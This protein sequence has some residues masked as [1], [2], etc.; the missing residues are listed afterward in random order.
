M[1]AFLTTV[2]FFISLGAFCQLA[3]VLLNDTSIT[4][5]LRD[6][7]VLELP[8]NSFLEAREGKGDVKYKM[9]A[10]DFK[11]ETV[12][13]CN[14]I[15]VGS[16]QE[17]D[18]GFT[19]L[20]KL[21]GDNCNCGFELFISV[22][23]ETQAY[24]SAKV[25]DPK[26]NRLTFKFK[27][28]DKEDFLGFGEQPSHYNLTGHKFPVF[29]E[30]QGLGRGD[31]HISGL[32]KLAGAAG[33]EYTSYAPIPFFLTDN[34]R[35]MLIDNTEYLEYDLTASETAKIT[36]WS[37][38]ISGWVWQ[39]EP[40]EILE[41]YT[42][43]SGRMPEL[44]DWAY[45]TWLGL[46]GGAEKVKTIVQGAMDAG[47]PVSAVWIQDWV[48]KRKT[49]IGSRLW[50]RWTPDEA[51]YPN[52]KQFNADM[53]E[54]GVKVLGYINS[55]L[56]D[57]GPMFEEAKSKGYLVKNQA[58]EDY[59]L[60]AGGFKAY[61]VDLTN[62][63]A[64]EWLKGIIKTNLIGNGFSGWMADFG[65]WLPF[66]AKLHSGE[67]A[68]SYHNQY[69]V[70]WARLNR[71]AIREAGKEGEIVFFSRSGFGYSNK[72][73]TLFWAGDQMNSWG[74]NDGL[75][76]AITTM[77]SSGMSGITLNHSDI[78][79]YTTVTVP[80][81]KNVRSRE[82]F[83]RWAEFA[84]F[85]P[86]FRTHEGLKPNKNFQFYD[87]AEGQAFFAKMGKMHYALKDYFQ[88]LGKEAAEKGWPIIRSPFLETQTQKVL[89][90][91]WYSFLVGS[92]LL[93]HPVIEKGA[94][95]V[96][97]YFPDGEWESVWTGGTI[98]GGDKVKVQAPL[99]QPAVYV[100][101]GGKWSERIK[102]ALRSAK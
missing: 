16:L 89:N 76:S 22:R 6:G 86:V 7:L 13:L 68:A 33:N 1:R 71:E 82:L 31:K 32:T 83:Y 102:K 69:P 96:V 62:P 45:G 8:L 61:L 66:D 81:W 48:G 77:I 41:Q 54:K 44:P 92:D 36:V 72:Y 29:C 26:L 12:R 2:F 40:L 27:K 15:E 64:F 19:F 51:S 90:E 46:Q 57:E 67:D 52:I 95:E 93:V 55:F 75:P 47:N 5:T 10:F 56:A 79:G 30:E 24:F 50:W 84:V 3:P 85:T 59:E 65:E 91:H 94:T 53:N 18:D 9:A 25:D 38:E 35:G 88:Y 14:Q 28:G 60:A 100:R 98:N 99:G 87:D 11:D 17:S 74:K 97:G 21:K 58:G 20:G 42:A 37:N 78:G 63:A 43:R 80:F 73:S 23:G 49:R 39:G 4:L 101:V 34:R 70:D